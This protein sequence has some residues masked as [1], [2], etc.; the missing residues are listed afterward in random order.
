MSTQRSLESLNRLVSSHCRGVADLEG[1]AAAR[2]ACRDAG[3][4]RGAGGRSGSLNAG[5][6]ARSRPGAPVCRCADQL[7]SDDSWPD[8]D[9]GRGFRCGL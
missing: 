3:S 2:L 9:S 6:S 8:E 1:S 7:V 5:S 4:P